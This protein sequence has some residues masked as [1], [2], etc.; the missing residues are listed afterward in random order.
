M[1]IESMEKAEERFTRKLK[2]EYRFV[3][4][5][6]REKLNVLMNMKLL[7]AQVQKNIHERELAGEKMEE[8]RILLRSLATGD[9]NVS[10]KALKHYKELMI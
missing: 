4:N 10:V 1:Y 2:R 6:M 9:P 7:F 3:A 5:P 8:S